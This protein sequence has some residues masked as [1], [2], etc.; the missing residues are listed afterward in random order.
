MSESLSRTTSLRGSES[1]RVLTP[2]SRHTSQSSFAQTDVTDVSSYKVDEVA[3]KL[4]FVTA[5]ANDECRGRAVGVRGKHTRDGEDEKDGDEEGEDGETR[6]GKE[7]ENWELAKAAR[8]V[9]LRSRFD[10]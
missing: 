7:K 2:D 3:E 6:R 1:S 5:E 10:F 9:W 4:Q 8:M